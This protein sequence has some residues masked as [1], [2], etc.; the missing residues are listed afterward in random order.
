MQLPLVA[1]R[2]ETNH[3][4]TEYTDHEELHSSSNDL[5]QLIGGYQ[6]LKNQL[7]MYGMVEYPIKGDGACQFASVS[8]QLYQSVAQKDHLRSLAIKQLIQYPEYYVEFVEESNYMDYCKKMSL[9]TT[10][11]DHITLQA[12][13]D[14]LNIVINLITSY[15]YQPHIE[16]RPNNSKTIKNHIWLSFHGEV[17]YNSLYPEE[18]INLRLQN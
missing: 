10:W 7:K 1:L 17:H 15:S 9:S 16:I 2:R 18:M 4:E 3:T 11:G 6:R 14:A 8:D 12:L 5:D 13:S